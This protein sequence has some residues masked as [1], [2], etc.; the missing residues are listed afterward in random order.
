MVHSDSSLSQNRFW[1][2][3][4]KNQFRQKLYSIEQ[5][6]LS[7]KNAPL[8]IGTG[9]GR[10]GNFE[11][12]W[13]MNKQVL[14]V[15]AT[16]DTWEYILKDIVKHDSTG[17]KYYVDNNKKTD[18]LNKVT[19]R[20]NRPFLRS[21]PSSLLSSLLHRVKPWANKS[22]NNFGK[23]VELAYLLPSYIDFRFGPQ[24]QL[25]G[26]RGKDEL[27]LVRK[28]ANK[29]I[30]FLNQRGYLIGYEVGESG[31]WLD[32]NPDYI[33]NRHFRLIWGLGGRSDFVI[34]LA[35]GCVEYW[36]LK[37]HSP[38][39]PIS[40]PDDLVKQEYFQQVVRQAPMQLIYSSN[41]PL[42]IPNVL[43]VKTIGVLGIGCDGEGNIISYNRQIEASDWEGNIISYDRKVEEPIQKP[44]PVDRSITTVRV[45]QWY[46]LLGTPEERVKLATE[47][48][49]ET[50][51]QLIEALIKSDE[52]DA[53]QQELDLH[54][55]RKWGRRV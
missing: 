42:P 36:D 10:K 23:W 26:N 40:K 55:E 29:A 19:M 4:L 38:N 28:Y 31:L 1:R 15:W 37:T 2:T 49:K 7:Q 54:W 44:F 43:P 53:I 6:P 17:K 32:G 14:M 33:P 24:L 25:A 46:E 47:V 16:S 9:M 5:L 52:W 8:L 13:N 11:L 35:N 3:S 20:S 51:H 18:F 12:S 21:Y 45:T 39:K 27:E 22:I 48:L 50:V 30:D 41:G 34:Q